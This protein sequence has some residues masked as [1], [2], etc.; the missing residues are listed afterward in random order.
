MNIKDRLLKALWQDP[1]YEIAQPMCNEFTIDQV[2]EALYGR[3]LNQ[4]RDAGAEFDGAKASFK[5]CDF[6]WNYDAVS[7][8]LRVACTK[9]P[10]YFTCDLV[11]SEIRK[12]VDQAR[13][14]L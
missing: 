6:N 5:G 9:K 3:L 14:A 1:N 7:G 12:L 10:F 8:T 11:E 2:D 13:A 4:A